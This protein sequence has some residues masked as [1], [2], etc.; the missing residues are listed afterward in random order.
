MLTHIK[1]ENF[2]SH[3][4][5]EFDL[6]E[7][8]VFLGANG[9]GKS[10]VLEAITLLAFCKSFREEDKKS[11]IHF[12]ADY[13]RIVAGEMEIFIQK[14]PT[15]IFKAKN[16]GL[17][18]KK[19]DFIGLLPTVVFSPETLSIIAGGPKERRRFLD[20]MIGQVDREYLLTLIN[21]EKVKEQRNS[22]LQK[23]AKGQGAASEL[24]YWDTKFLEYARL[25]IAKRQEVISSLNQ[26]L[27]NFYSEISGDADQELQLNYTTT[28]TPEIIDDIHSIRAREIA[29]GRSQFGPHRDDFKVVLNSRNMANYAS[30]GEVRSAILSLKIT[31]ICFL[32]KSLKNTDKKPILLL[33]DIFSE[34]DEDR[35]HH[36]DKL[37]EGYQ[38]IITT[39]DEI[40]L[41]PTLRQK[42]VVIRLERNSE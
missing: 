31:E 39:T 36:L 6:G 33:D 29:S 4:R 34:F 20:V 3:L 22:L 40:F 26:S 11:L 1:L 8:T 10:N 25:I 42:A 5:A 37:I 16:K 38:T 2:R 12:D 30:R 35:R 17:F 14:S 18:S 13:A 15:S 28:L 27:S 21:F 7:V 9:A 23:L 24:D 32:E 41:S 19:V